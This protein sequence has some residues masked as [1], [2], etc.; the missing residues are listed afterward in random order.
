MGFKLCILPSHIR[1]DP[2][3]IDHKR[4]QVRSRRCLFVGLDMQTK[5][6]FFSCENT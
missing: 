1:L 4:D 5:L 6:A 2:T 3:G